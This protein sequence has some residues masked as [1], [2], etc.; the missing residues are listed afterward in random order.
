MQYFDTSMAR[1]SNE[2]RPAEAPPP[3]LPLTDMRTFTPGTTI[4]TAQPFGAPSSVHD[5]QRQ[6]KQYEDFEE[7]QPGL[8][9][10]TLLRQTGLGIKIRFLLALTLTAVFPA[11]IL[12]ILLGDP[13][14]QEQRAAL[15]QALILQARAQAG[16]IDQA[17][18][19]RQ[20]LVSS[21]AQRSLLFQL[22]TRGT[23]TNGQ[24]TTLLQ[25]ARQVDPSSLAWMVVRSDSKIV[26]A[27]DA[28]S[29]LAGLKLSQVKIVSSPD[30]LMQLVQAVS[31]NATA[32]N[33]LLSDDAN[34]QGGWL[35]IAFSVK[36][37]N[38][39]SGAVL[40]AVF[41]LQKVTQ[42]LITTT[43]G[44]E[45]MAVALLDRQGRVVLSAG[46]LASGQKAF[47]PAPQSLQ[48]LPLGTST[49][50]IINNDAL[51]GR[52]DIAVGVPLKTL[53]GRYL[54]MV[55]PDTTLA[56]STRVFFA[57]RNTPL[58]I[59][60]IL[61]VVVLVATWVALPIVRPI[62]RATREIGFTTE[63]VR[64]L[65]HDA[66]R[67]A[68]E[69]A[70]GTTLLSGASKRLG[71]RRQSIIRDGMTIAQTCGALWPRVQW[72]QQIAQGSQNKQLMETL[73]VLQQ[74]LYHINELG[75]SIAGGLEKDTTLNQLDGAMESAREISAQFEAAGVQ[76]ERGAEQ[77][78]L[79]ARTLL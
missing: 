57:G 62:R 54:L 29:R 72:L 42:G 68:Q 14:G 15:G 56:P 5:E 26:I 66:R 28:S 3:F 20:S 12:V 17:I 6:Q 49:P 60:A 70:I 4:N 67:I 18:A 13:S 46:A 2:R 1:G 7:N 39:S 24:V 11:I 25:D 19:T 36:Q 23:D 40:L 9:L 27:G 43:G 8:T 75:T 65:A 79:A 44:L 16:A 69:H 76:L 58:L 37:N 78:E 63:E 34:I 38:A 71:G 48:T 50:A 41:S 52:T 47:I 45:G 10:R 33:L 61:V 77:L 74:G 21:L 53:S 30:K 55:P 51:T 73:Q 22:A 59:L 35:A 32:G 31:V 64:K